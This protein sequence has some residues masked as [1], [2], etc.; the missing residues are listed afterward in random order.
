MNIPGFTSSTSY[1]YIT[2]RVYLHIRYDW[3]LFNAG[4][5]DGAT[6]LRHNVNTIWTFKTT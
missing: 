5:F 3:L 1:N 4:Q 2:S 6:L